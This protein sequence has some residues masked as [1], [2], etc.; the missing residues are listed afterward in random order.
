MPVSGGKGCNADLLCPDRKWHHS[1]Q[2]GGNGHGHNG[3]HYRDTLSKSQAVVSF[4][5]WRPFIAMDNINFSFADEP[6]QLA[7]HQ[8]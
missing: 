3:S 1:R 8:H 2:E 7:E 4:D 6:Y 5:Y